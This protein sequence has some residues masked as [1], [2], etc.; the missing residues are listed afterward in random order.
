[1][2]KCREGFEKNH[3]ELDL[4]FRNGLYISV[5]T[6][7]AW[8]TWQRAWNASHDSCI[9]VCREKINQFS[10]AEA[11]KVYIEFS[12]IIQNDKVEL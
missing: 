5:V 8:M 12:E 4:T 2:D 6:H 1:M 9:E 10:K 3:L 7:N 11:K